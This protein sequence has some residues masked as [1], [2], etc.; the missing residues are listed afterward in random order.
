MV[1]PARAEMITS[2]KRITPNL[3]NLSGLLAKQK[4][5]ALNL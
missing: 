3:Y 4:Y 5:L 1:L 2:L